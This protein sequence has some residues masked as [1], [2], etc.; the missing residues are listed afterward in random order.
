[1]CSIA[2]SNH[3]RCNRGVPGDHLGAYGL[4]IRVSQDNCIT[5]PTDNCVSN[6][7]KS[8]VLSILQ[9]QTA[10][11]LMQ[12]IQGKN[13]D[14]EDVEKCIPDNVDGLVPLMVTTGSAEELS[15]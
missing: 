10:N 1:M 8:D 12:A 9:S 5:A 3:D 4:E 14:N 11:V 6:E 7:V 13:V 15:I 2:P